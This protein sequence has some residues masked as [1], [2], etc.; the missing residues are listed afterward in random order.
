[1]FMLGVTQLSWQDIKGSMTWIEKQD[2]LL[3]SKRSSQAQSKITEPQEIPVC[4]SGESDEIIA[5]D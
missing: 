1:M 5:Q 3:S 4:G 2:T